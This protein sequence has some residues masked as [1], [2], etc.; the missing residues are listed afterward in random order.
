MALKQMH[1]RT[2]SF[3]LA[4]L[5]CSEASSKPFALP[6]FISSIALL[7]S[8]VWNVRLKL[9]QEHRESLISSAIGEDGVQF[10]MP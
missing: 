9:A 1:N 3:S 6:N 5:K 7:I 4:Y 2:Y 8:V 10:K